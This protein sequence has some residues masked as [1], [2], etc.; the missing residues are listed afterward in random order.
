MKMLAHRQRVEETLTER[1]QAILRYLATSLSIA[2]IADAEFVSVNTA[3]THMAH[4]YR[5]LGVSGR[6][7]AVRRAGE[8]G[9]I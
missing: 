3:K 4:I 7:A 5:K 8:L 6:R 9:L 2:E 1:E